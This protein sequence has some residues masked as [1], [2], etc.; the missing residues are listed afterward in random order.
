MK[1]SGAHVNWIEF[2][3]LAAA[4]AKLA[5]DKTHFDQVIPKGQDFDDDD[6]VGIFCF[7]FWKCGTWEEVVIDDR[8]PTINNQL[9]Y[10]RSKEPNEFWG[11]LL[12]KALAK[13]HGS[14]RAIESGK[15]CEG[16]VSLTGG[17]PELMA[18]SDF[19]SDE[20]LKELF[21]I[22][23]K[24]VNKKAYIGTSLKVCEH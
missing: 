7:H 15:F 14:Y 12:E 19:E 9:I 16:S 21:K 1:V 8:L 4:V 10:T 11:A 18:V 3:N 5:E 2:L 23:K 13:W 17:I 20:K 6:Y 24:A 22:L